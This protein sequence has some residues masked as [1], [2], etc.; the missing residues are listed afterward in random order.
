[1]R[2]VTQDKSKIFNLPEDEIWQIWISHNLITDKYD[3]F[4]VVGKTG[5]QEKIA[6]Y[7]DR[8]TAEFALQNVIKM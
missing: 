2:I 5:N 6:Q 7:E 3:M 8:E 1:M 4:L